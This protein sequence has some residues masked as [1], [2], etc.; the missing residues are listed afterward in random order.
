MQIVIIGIKAFIMD[1]FG[2]R[3]RDTISRFLVRSDDILIYAKR[4]KEGAIRF[5]QCFNLSLLHA[6]LPVGLRFRPVGLRSS[7]LG[8]WFRHIP[9][10]FKLK[11]HFFHVFSFFLL[12]TTRDLIQRKQNQI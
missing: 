8:L 6:S 5:E 7:F 12:I 3:L 9:E 2:T 10:A 1:T 4:T 11:I